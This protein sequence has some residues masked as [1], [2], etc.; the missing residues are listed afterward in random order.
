MKV[1]VLAAEHLVTVSRGRRATVTPIPPLQ[2]ID[3]AS[4]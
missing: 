1:A 3:Q 4:T 2:A